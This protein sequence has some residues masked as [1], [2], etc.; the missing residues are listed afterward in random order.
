MAK[1]T[2]FMHKVIYRNSRQS[3]SLWTSTSVTSLLLAK[4]TLTA[5]VY[6]VVTALR[7]M[8]S[9]NVTFILP[10]KTAKISVKPMQ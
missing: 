2:C 10:L 9:Y 6:E 4:S 7:T 5:P 8:R 3:G 1:T